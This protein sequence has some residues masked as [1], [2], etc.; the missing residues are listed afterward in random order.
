MLADGRG[1]DGSDAVPRAHAAHAPDEHGRKEEAEARDAMPNPF[2]K[3]TSFREGPLRALVW[4]V[5]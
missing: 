4:V 5:R 1:H 2:R 3:W